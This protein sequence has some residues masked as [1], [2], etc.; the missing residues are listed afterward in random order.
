MHHFLALAFG[1]ITLGLVCA[2]YYSLKPA[3]TE[4]WQHGE[5][6][7]SILISSLTGSFLLS[8]AIIGKEIWQLAASGFNQAAPLY[9]GLDLVSAGLIVASL[10]VYRAILKMTAGKLKTTDNVSPFPTRPVTPQPP[11]HIDRK[12]A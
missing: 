9:L 12:A 1:L 3:R 11:V 8:V 10:L 2:A 6:Y 7:L 5:I 4:N